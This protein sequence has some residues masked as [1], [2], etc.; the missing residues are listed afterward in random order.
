MGFIDGVGG[1]SSVQQVDDTLGRCDVEL[2]VDLFVE[3]LF[4]L[5]DVYGVEVGVRNHQDTPVTRNREVFDLRFGRRAIV[6]D[7]VARFNLD[8]EVVLDARLDY[9][10]GNVLFRAVFGIGERAPWVRIVAVEVIGVQRAVLRHLWFEVVNRLLDDVVV[11]FV[12]IEEDRC[13]DQ[14]AADYVLPNYA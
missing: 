6:L 8:D 10:V 9:H 1:G 7:R 11:I 5:I 2:A 4:K 13:P 12:R 3:V 14:C